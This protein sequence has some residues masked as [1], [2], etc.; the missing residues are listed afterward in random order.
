MTGF[1]FQ[2]LTMI[3]AVNPPAAG[4]AASRPA[5]RTQGAIAAGF[6]FL[7]LGTAALLATPALNWLDVAPESFRTAAGIVMAVQ[8][9]SMVWDP[10]LNYRASHEPRAGLV[11]LGWPVLANAAVILA[12]MSFAADSANG[13]VIAVGAIAAV[14]GGAG[15]ALPSRFDL[16]MRGGARLCGAFLVVAAAALIV[17]GVRD[18]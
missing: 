7:L 18:V 5:R 17:S 1:W 15:A 10:T 2:L 13:Q 11:P 14:A 12:T 4:L 3:V 8:G 16:S 9:G 6:A